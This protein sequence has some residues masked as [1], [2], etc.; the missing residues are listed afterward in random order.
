MLSAIGRPAPFIPLSQRSPHRI[1]I[2]DHCIAMQ[3]VV[4]FLR[5]D[6]QVRWR[7][8]LRVEILVVNHVSGKNLCSEGVFGDVTMLK[9]IRR[10]AVIDP[11]IVLR[12]AICLRENLLQ[13]SLK[14]RHDLQAVTRL[15]IPQFTVR[16]VAETELVICGRS[17]RR[18]VV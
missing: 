16:S 8:V 5:Q 14:T 1:A 3:T 10:L 6:C 17:H 12:A 18:A 15:E 13:R 2:T 7:I 9:A 4:L 11:P